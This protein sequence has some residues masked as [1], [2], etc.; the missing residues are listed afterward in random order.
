M[1]SRK[2]SF[3]EKESGIFWDT[4]EDKQS[5]FIQKKEQEQRL[6]DKELIKM[7]IKEEKKQREN[8][9]KQKN[10]AQAHKVIRTKTI[11]RSDSTRDVSISTNATNAEKGDKTPIKTPIPTHT[12]T[13]PQNTTATSTKP[14]IA[15]NTTTT[16]TSHGVH[17]PVKPTE[18]LP[19]NVFLDTIP[20][21]ID[22]E[23][24]DNIDF[25]VL[26]SSINNL[27]ENIKIM[28]ITPKVIE[29]GRKHYN[30]D[31]LDGVELEHLGGM[32]SAF[33]HWSKK[34]LTQNT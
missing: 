22:V 16:N 24:P 17:V 21:F 13:K 20:D 28:I 10:I 9:I 12:P 23:F 18:P 29:M 19:P 14:L 27:S 6:I 1:Q 30:C 3:I 5:L 33:S 34:F 2:S 32:G 8:L 7:D 4:E 26:L 25:T 31:S 15:S 11:L